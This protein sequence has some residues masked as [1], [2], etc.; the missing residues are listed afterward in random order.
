MN[1]NR[2]L[3]SLNHLLKILLQLPA[4]IAPRHEEK[5]V[6]AKTKRLSS[7]DYAKENRKI[8]TFTQWW[9]QVRS[10]RRG[11]KAGW[12]RKT[13]STPP[14]TS[15]RSGPATVTC[16]SKGDSFRNQFLLDLLI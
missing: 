13:K 12:A 14:P 4:R 1:I 6:V 3:V 15:A 10:N 11:S 8:L 9:I 5:F 16:R 7:I 2:D